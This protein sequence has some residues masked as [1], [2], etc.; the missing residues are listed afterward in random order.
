M[1]VTNTIRVDIAPAEAWRVVGDLTG[2]DSWIPGVVSATVEGDRRLCETADGGQ[3]VERITS[4]SDD[5]RSYGYAH[6]QQPLPIENSRGTLSVQPDRDGAVIVWEAS[7]EPPD[8]EIGG[9]VER[10]YRETLDSLARLLEEP[11]RPAA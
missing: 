5:D 2:V 8:A 1:K 7:F 10:A 11:A 9:M 6:I 4:Y 3:I